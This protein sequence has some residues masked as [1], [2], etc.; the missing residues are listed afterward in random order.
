MWDETVAALSQRYRIQYHALTQQ[1]VVTNLNT[2]ERTAHNSQQIAL[3]SI[4]HISHLPVIDEKL[5]HT[6]KVYYGRVRS[7]LVIKK[8]PSPLR[9]WAYMSS[10]WRLK[11]EWYQWQL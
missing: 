11:S 6:D 3:E 5:L 10:D 2:N 9:L 7:R 1:Y 4:S 8:L